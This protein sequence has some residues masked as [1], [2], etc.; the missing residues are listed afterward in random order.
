MQGIRLKNAK[1]MALI[2]QKTMVKAFHE[3]YFLMRMIGPLGTNENWSYVR[4][5]A[6]E[7]AETDDQKG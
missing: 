7:T 2:E 5:A 3:P 4:L 1:M 6:F